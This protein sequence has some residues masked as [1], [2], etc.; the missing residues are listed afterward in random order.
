MKSLTTVVLL[1]S[2][3]CISHADVRMPSLFSDRMVLQQKTENIV[4]GFADPGEKVSV[5]ANW[6]K[7]AKTTANAVGKWRVPLETPLHGTGYTI[8]I[9]GNNA[10]VLK[11]V[12]IGE[13][14]LCAGLSLIHISEP[15]RLLSNACAGVGL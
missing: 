8:T 1:F 10:I 15:T 2:V 14:W 3:Q 12:A 6:G 9:R 11:D 13:V 5:E 7:T 4:W